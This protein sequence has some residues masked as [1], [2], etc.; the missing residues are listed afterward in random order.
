MA[1]IQQKLIALTFDDGPSLYTNQILDILDGYTIKATFFVVGEAVK[2]YPEIIRRI[3]KE[4]HVI[5]NHTWNH[6]SILEISSVELSD[7]IVKTNEAIKEVLNEEPILFRA[8]YGSIDN[9]SFQL[10]RSLGLTSVLWNV[11]SLDWSINESSALEKRI[12]K[13]TV[14]D[15]IILLHDGNQYGSGPRDVTVKSLPQII[16]YLIK[17]GYTFVTIPEFH[18]HC[19]KI[20]KW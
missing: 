19:F 11:D 17:E 6:P 15:S 16:D 13:D 3:K 5:G 20:E 1:N 14:S 18:Q 2:K 7:Q 12:K 8:P 9:E 10:I 4:N